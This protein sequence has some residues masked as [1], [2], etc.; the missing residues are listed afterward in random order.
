MQN[1]DYLQEPYNHC[2]YAI[3][4]KHWPYYEYWEQTLIMNPKPWLKHIKLGVSRFCK[5]FSRSWILYILIKKIRHFHSRVIRDES[6]LR[7]KLYLL[8]VYTL[9]WFYARLWKNIK[10]TYIKFSV[11][12][13]SNGW[14]IQ[15]YWFR[16]FYH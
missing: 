5:F 12:R 8:V 10:L 9:K 13:P 16:Q 11:L 7:P 4:Y 15:N 1:T 6:Y 14:W 3:F 2:V